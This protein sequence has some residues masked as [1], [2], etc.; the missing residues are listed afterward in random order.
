[1]PF[2]EAMA[3]LRSYLILMLP[4]S[5]K[6]RPHCI[7]PHCWTSLAVSWPTLLLRLC[8]GQNLVITIWVCYRQVDLINWDDGKLAKSKIALATPVMA[9]PAAFMGTMDL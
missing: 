1:M 7:E 2:I 4:H 9:M 5:G 3:Q 6:F 8:C